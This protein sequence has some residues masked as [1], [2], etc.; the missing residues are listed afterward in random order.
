MSQAFA[1]VQYHLFHLALCAVPAFAFGGPKL[2]KPPAAAVEERAVS[3][4]RLRPP[5]VFFALGAEGVGVMG[6][7]PSSTQGLTTLVAFLFQNNSS[8]TGKL[9]LRYE[10]GGY[11]LWIQWDT[12]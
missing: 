1:N 9:P 12:R 8:L 2:P 7:L 4:A 6:L 10:L 3:P 11:L 5:R